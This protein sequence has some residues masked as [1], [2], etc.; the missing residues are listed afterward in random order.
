MKKTGF[1]GGTDDRESPCN[2]GALGFSPGSGKIHLTG[3]Y[4]QFHYSCLKSPLSKKPCRL[5][6]MGITKC[7]TCLSD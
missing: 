7:Q 6:S 2:V 4:Y 3:N 1:P 5:Q